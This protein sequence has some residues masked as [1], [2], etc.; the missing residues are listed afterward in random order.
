MIKFRGFI[1]VDIDAKP[2]IVQ[3]LKDITSSNADVKLV[4]PQNIHV[5]LKFLG[6]VQDDKIDQIEQI[7]KDSVE[8]VKPFTVKLIG[9]GV[10]P[11]KNYIRVVW[12]GIQDAE[13]IVTISGNIN[14]KLSQIGFKKEKRGFSA[15]LTV[16]RVKTAKNKEVLLKTIEKY[17]NFEFSIQEVNSI[18]LKKSELT[19]KGPIYTTLKEVK[20]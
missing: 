20:L 9:T 12:I 6:D 4:E 11:N 14:E 1:A 3:F 15:H 19:P 8:E 13:N 2:V 5:T 18:K 10:F 17:R 7:M 16:G